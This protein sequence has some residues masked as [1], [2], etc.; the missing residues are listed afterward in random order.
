MYFFLLFSYP[1][2]LIRW[3]S[4][5]PPR[6]RRTIRANP[7][8][9]RIATAF[10]YLAN[11]LRFQSDCY[12]VQRAQS[13][14]FEE[15]SQP[16]SP[17]CPCPEWSSPWMAAA[18][19]T[20]PRP[21]KATRL[22]RIALRHAEEG[23]KSPASLQLQLAHCG[24]SHRSGEKRAVIDTRSSIRHKSRVSPRKRAGS[25][26]ARRRELLSARARPNLRTDGGSRKPPRGAAAA[27]SDPA[28]RLPSPAAL[29][30]ELPGGSGGVRTPTPARVTP[31]GPYSGEG[32]RPLALPSRPGG[33]GA[34]APPHGHSPAAPEPDP[35]PRRLPPRGP[36]P[37]RHP[38]A[39]GRAAAAA[40]PFPRGRFPRGRPAGLAP[41]PARP[42]A[43]TW[44]SAVSPST[45]A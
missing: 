15:T 1:G 34:E 11:V 24:R 19:A 10:P 23:C 9:L 21:N 20:H 28:E 26:R 45:L 43:P 30:R 3:G 18:P 6:K 13:I 16:V 17:P 7:H 35:A 5:W 25:L 37:P 31:R 22:R 38:P 42:A 8:Y 32:N 29:P 36:S 4:F 33:S 27:G 14:H 44:W 41:G 40:G 39:E 2:N 12:E